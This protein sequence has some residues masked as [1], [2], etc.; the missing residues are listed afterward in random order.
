MMRSFD[1]AI[2]GDLR[3]NPE[4]TIEGEMLNPMLTSYYSYTSF[5]PEAYTVTQH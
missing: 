5:W 2:Y 4:L 1:H 3:Y